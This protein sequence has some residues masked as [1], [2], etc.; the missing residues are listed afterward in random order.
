[1]V[2]KDISIKIIDLCHSPILIGIFYQDIVACDVVD[3]DVCHVLLGRPWQH[4]VDVTHRAK[5]NIYVFP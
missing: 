2:K 3:M 1:L 4:D 5:E